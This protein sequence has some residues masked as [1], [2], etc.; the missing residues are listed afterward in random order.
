MSRIE[1]LRI[2]LIAKDIAYDTV[3]KISQDALQEIQEGIRD[4]EGEIR[5]EM[6][7]ML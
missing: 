2:Q 7:E 1:D 6:E 4:I 5:D 3:N